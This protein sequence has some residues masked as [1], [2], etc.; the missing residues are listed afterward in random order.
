MQLLEDLRSNQIRDEFLF[1]FQPPKR[2]FY[3][4]I[5][6]QA[7]GISCTLASLIF[8]SNC[9]PLGNLPFCFID[10]CLVEATHCHR[11]MHY[12]TCVSV[13]LFR[14]FR[15]KLISLRRIEGR[16]VLADASNSYWNCHIPVGFQLEWVNLHS[17]VSD[18]KKFKKI[19]QN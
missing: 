9:I 7:P 11:N 18:K 8:L 14:F 17:V 10:L 3:Y 2:T 16:V 5:A 13:V 15:L 6:V 1:V 12:S 4:P 19:F